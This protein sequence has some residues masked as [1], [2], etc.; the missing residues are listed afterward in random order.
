M[1]WLWEV[2]AP[3]VLACPLWAPATPPPRA[4]AC[5]LQAPATGPSALA[6][7]NA[8]PR[9]SPLR[10]AKACALQAGLGIRRGANQRKAPRY[11]KPL[12]DAAVCRMRTVTHRRLARATRRMCCGTADAPAL[13]AVPAA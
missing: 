10:P 13:M 9:G 2:L 8:G 11:Q 6:C 3:S 4:L 7:R 1:D 5:P 12:Y